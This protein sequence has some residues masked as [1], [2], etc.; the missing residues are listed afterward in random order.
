MDK[1]ALLHRATSEMAFYKK[2]DLLHLRFRAKRNDLVDVTVLIGPLRHASDNTPWPHQEIMLERSFVTK[3]HDY[4]TIDLKLG[5]N[6][7]Q[8]IF[9]VTDL[10]GEIIFYD[11]QRILPA[12]ENNINYPH[13]FLIPTR[14]KRYVQ[15]VP[16]WANKTIWYQIQVDRFFDGDKYLNLPDT[17][18]WNEKEFNEQSTFGGDLQGI[19]GKLDYLQG[20]G[21][22]GLVLSSIFE[23][24]GAFKNPVN[25]YYS[26]AHNFGNKDTF[27]YL[28][29]NMHQRGMRIMLE[30]NFAFL[31]DISRQWRDVL[32]NGEESQYKDWFMIKGFPPRYT[33]TTQTLHANYKFSLNNPHFP[34]LNLKNKEVQNY[35]LD[36]VKYWVKHFK[37]DA[38]KL[39]NFAELEKEFVQLLQKEVHQLNP[40]FYLV[41]QDSKVSLEKETYEVADGK[42]NHALRELLLQFTQDQEIKVNEFKQ[43]FSQQLLYYTDQ[44]WMTMLNSMDDLDSPRILTRCR[45]DKALVRAVIA[46]MYLQKGMPLL[47]Y[48]IEIGMLGHEVPENRGTMFFDEDVE[49]EKMMRFIRVL[50]NFRLQNA[51]LLSEGSFNWGQVSDT[52]SYLSFIRKDDKRKVFALFNFGYASIKFVLPNHAKLI[53]GQ[54]IKDETSELTQYGFVIMEA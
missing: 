20:I 26:L 24:Q 45:Q 49:D 16:S 1:A 44:Q 9:K 53:I 6:A 11:T 15:Y 28:V 37:I 38:I 32:E 13:G 54:N 39:E 5:D 35:F 43:Q 21:T 41:G 40:D 48:G 4:W 42:F 19:L 25:D 12:S 30:M 52:Y 29:D 7:A 14:N 2:K 18:E 10:H 23:G 33:D 47:T 3:F 8:Y 34:T 36:V 22:N 31:S 17:K 50:N 51:K 27:K 46:F